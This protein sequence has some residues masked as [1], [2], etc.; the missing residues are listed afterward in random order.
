MRVRLPRAARALA[1]T[2]AALALLSTP[3]MASAATTIEPQAAPAAVAPMAVPTPTSSQSVVV[4]QVGGARTGTGTTVS[5]LA[6]AQLGLFTSPSAQSPVSSSWG[7][8]TSDADGQCSFV[9]PNTGQGGQNGNRDRELYVRAIAAPAGYTL[10]TQFGTASSSSS[11]NAQTY[12]FR[13]G[14]RPDGQGGS[15]LLRGGMTYSSLNAGHFMLSSGTAQSASGGIF[16]FPMANVPAVQLCGLDIALV[17]DVSG[18][19]AGYQNQLAGAASTLVNSLQGTDSTV[20][21]YSFSTL[22]PGTVWGSNGNT[23]QVVLANHPEQQ[24]VATADGAAIVNGWFSNADGTASFTPSGGTNWDRGLWAVHASGNDYDVAVVITD[25]NPTFYNAPQEGDGSTTRFREVE[26]GVLSANVVKEDGTR[27]VALGVGTGVTSAGS[28][29]NLAAISGP[30]AGDDYYQTTDYAAAA[31]ALRELALADCSGTVTIVKQVVP[32]GTDGEDVTG[33]EVAGG[34]TFDAASSN[35]LVTV[36]ADGTTATATGAVNFPLEFADAGESTDLTFTEQQQDGFSIVTQGGLNASCVDILTGDP[37]AV[38]NAGADGFS[39]AGV[40]NGAAI[41]C[42]VYNR[43][44]ELDA[45]VLVHKQW[46]ID[47]VAY[48]NGQ[49]PAGLTATLELSGPEGAPSSA[50]PWSQARDGYVEGETVTIDESTEIAPTLAGCTIVSQRV[51]LENGETIDAEVPYEA[52]LD[53]GDNELTV[54]NVVECES[55]LTLVKDVIG[56]DAEADEWTLTA[57]TSPEGAP[58]DGVEVF[59]GTTGVTEVIAADTRYQL[60]ESGPGVYLQ[61][62]LRTDIQVSPLSTGSWACILVDEDL[63]PIPGSGYNDGINGGVTVPLGAHVQCTATNRTAELTLLKV[64]PDGSVTQPADWTL[65]ATPASDD[66]PGDVTEASVTGAPDV[67]DDGSADDNT[68]LVLPGHDYAIAESGTGATLNGELQQYVGVVGDDGSVDHANPD[69]WV[70]VDDPSA[71][72]V[73]AGDHAI[74]RFVNEDAPAFTLPLTGGTGSM[75]YWL[76][77]GAL[78]ALAAIGWLVARGIRR[79]TL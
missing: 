76:G 19:V 34:W 27:I 64:V 10:P 37:V 47:G 3:T 36:P 42:T 61:D 39:V 15:W 59:S 70:T 43:A 22:S 4:V 77:G 52:T 6:G 8:C 38:T 11:T 72:T 44:A 7:V 12:A 55:T 67:I 75:P 40:G 71:I 79:R 65:T 9:I 45:T 69:L 14:D 78:L 18:S 58:E 13:V 35:G 30:T 24:Q 28:G 50:Q 49:Q 53:A 23:S 1:A 73:A 17:L 31:Q 2:A 57:Y 29:I 62:D 48:G 41:T 46:V 54:T 63:E 26:N 5:N 56:G 51:T 16:T 25:G 21:M 32:T 33:A 74:Y 66:L 60:G 68:F 20:S